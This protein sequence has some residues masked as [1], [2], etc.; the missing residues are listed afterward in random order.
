MVAE[1]RDRKTK[2]ESLEKDLET[3]KSVLKKHSDDIEVIKT[4]WLPPLR[5][6]I[7]KINTN[8]RLEL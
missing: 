4:N 3:K 5:E 7:G 2:I 6:L 8:F 1:Y